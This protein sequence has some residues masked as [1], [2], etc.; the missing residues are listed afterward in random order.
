MTTK[1]GPA[2]GGDELLSQIENHGGPWAKL[3]IYLRNYLKPAV[4][5]RGLASY[6]VA[7]PSDAVGTATLRPVSEVVAAVNPPGAAYVGTSSTGHVV[8]APTPVGGTGTAGYLAEFT[9]AST[10][11]DSPIDNGVTAPATVTVNSN[12]KV[13]GS[14]TTT[15]SLST[16]GL[17]LAYVA[18]TANYTV[19]ADDYQIECTTGTFT[20]TLL[21]AAGITG[22]VYSIKNTGTGIIT[23]NT[24]SSQTIDGNLTQTLNQW[25]N[26]MVM[27]NGANWIII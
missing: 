10:V 1:G 4:Q 13:L 11:A 2:I 21:T 9:A 18:K 6:V 27:S 25:D 19:G 15:G 20:V 17:T 22:K 14:L 3:G 12:T 16:K 26:L 7:T 5:P 8:A 24:T 23:V